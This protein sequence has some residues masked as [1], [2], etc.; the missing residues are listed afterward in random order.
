MSAF[1]SAWQLLKAFQEDAGMYG[2]LPRSIIGMVERARAQAGES[3][4]GPVQ[5]T[6]RRGMERNPETGEMART[7]PFRSEPVDV[8]AGEGEKLP[9]SNLRI[10]RDLSPLQ[11]TYQTMVSHGI[12][13]H[14]GTG[15]LVPSTSM[16][17]VMGHE[18]M[19]EE[20]FYTPKEARYAREG[21]EQAAGRQ[22]TSGQRGGRMDMTG[23]SK[24]GIYAPL[25]GQTDEGKRIRVANRRA[26]NLGNVEGMR[27]GARLG[28][29]S[30]MFTQGAGAGEAEQEEQQAPTQEERIAAILGHVA[31]REP[32]PAAELGQDPQSLREMREKGR[33]YQMLVDAGMSHEEANKRQGLDSYGLPFDIEH[34]RQGIYRR[35]GGRQ[36]STGMGV[37]LDE[38]G[39]QQAIAQGKARREGDA[40]EPPLPRNERLRPMGRRAAERLEQSK[41][42]MPRPNLN[43]PQQ[44]GMAEMFADPSGPEGQAAMQNFQQVDTANRARLMQMAKEKAL[45]QA[46]IN[47]Q[48]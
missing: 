26:A 22:L 23:G 32:L 15:E 3:G 30:R 24:S 25:R 36:D 27:Q 13:R 44:P 40:K 37:N 17:N 8:V 20:S 39:I 6:D 4:R 1:A 2:T 34:M 46:N 16:A 14:P 42:A 45:E 47:R 18:L 28:G 29:M 21:M 9:L 48:G 35:G 12:N 10:E 7:G 5:H 41:T 38:K 43:I 33:N 31:S 19:P 11:E